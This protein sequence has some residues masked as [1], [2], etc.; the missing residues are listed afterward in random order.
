MKKSIEDI[1][2][3]G[4]RVIVR[5]DF[6]VPMDEENNITEDMR[7]VSAIPTIKY[8]ID[9]QSKVILMSHLGRPKGNVEPRFSL[10]PVAKRLSEL[11]GKEVYFSDDDTVVGDKT[12]KAVEGMKAGD[13]ILLQ[14]L[15]FRKEETK[16]EPS[17]SKE[18][19]SLADIY[20]NDAFGSSHRVHCSTFGIADYIPAVS[21][22]LLKKELD[23]LESALENPERPL[24]V[25]LGGAKVGDK[26]S[27]IEN[28]INKA[29]TIIIGGGMAYTFLNAKGFNTGQ[30]L[31]EEDKIDFARSLLQQAK[32]KNVKVLLPVDVCVTKEFKNDTEFKCIKID[33]IKDDEMGMDMGEETIK[34][35][36]DEIARSRTI[37]WNG[38]MGVFEM[39]NF[40]KGTREIARALTENAGVTII[41]GGD[42][43]AAVQQMGFAEKMTHISTGGGATL[44][45]LKGKDLPGVAI[46][47]DM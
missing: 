28:L 11:L 33:K 32:E 36:T 6:N 24:T 23:I 20:V 1:S 40:A 7:I 18:L 16:N 3:N 47:E 19:A 14:N 30:S 45:F 38:P 39:P 42:S 4:K 34:L 35:F 29:D 43:G 22:F 12:R 13:V 8:L 5:C 17:F 46:L 2:V 25:I 31:V 27:A 21:G 26:I 9:H 10:A 44:E 41:G 15:R 37:I